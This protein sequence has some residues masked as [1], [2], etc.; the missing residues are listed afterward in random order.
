LPYQKQLQGQ[1]DGRCTICSS[2]ANILKTDFGVGTVVNCSRCGDFRVDHVVADDVPLPLTDDKQKALASY[3][4]RGMQNQQRAVLT[5]EFFTSL[6]E[7]SLPAPAELCDNVLLWFS[8]QADGRVGKIIG[9]GRALSDPD[10]IARTGAIDTGDMKWAAEALKKGG[11]IVLEIDHQF[12]F[13]GNLTPAGWQRV[14]DLRR[15]HTSSNYAF[16]ARQFKNDE[17]DTLYKS[18]LRQ[19]VADTGYELHT[20]TQRAG[21]I[22]AIIEDEIRRCRFLIA[23][24]SDDNAGAYWEAGFAEGLGKDVIYI[25]REKE[26]DDK[27]DKKTHFDTDHRQTVRWDL[28][29]LAETATRLKAVIRNTLLGDAKQED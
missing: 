19:A 12:G 26:K 27:T 5:R 14:E 21:H 7:Q 15:A 29:K 11:L 17:L 24:L 9:T 18:C 22:N 8:E 20:V 25:C 13:R 6:G 28:T 16:F 10:F 1:P 3:L 4:I 2:P 23:D